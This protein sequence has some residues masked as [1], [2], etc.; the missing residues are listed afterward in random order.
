MDHNLEELFKTYK[1]SNRVYNV[2]SQQDD[3]V[4]LA[5]DPKFQGNFLTWFDTVK[6]RMKPVE[7]V[8]KADT[9]EFSFI[10]DNEVIYTFLPL[11]IDLYENNVK[12]H[13]IAPESYLNLED[14]E[15]KI[16]H[17][18]QSAW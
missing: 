2:I 3:T 16:I 18:I 14:L 4:V 13:L 5:V 10:S 1:F 12:Q 6:E 7:R 9:N 17:T 8:I 15:A 11:T